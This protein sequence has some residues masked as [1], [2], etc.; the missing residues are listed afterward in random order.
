MLAFFKGSD[1]SA[2]YSSRL[3][4]DYG[5]GISVFR[6]ELLKILNLF[7]L[8][9]AVLFTH[10]LVVLPFRFNPGV[11]AGLLYRRHATSS[12]PGTPRAALV[13]FGLA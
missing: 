8:N 10:A 4:I 5:E 11:K 13:S 12:P 1:T 2:P 7:G 6:R 3:P 9:T